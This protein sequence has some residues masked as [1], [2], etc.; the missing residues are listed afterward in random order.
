MEINYETHENLPPLKLCKDDLIKL[1]DILINELENELEEGEECI[2]RIDITLKDGKVTLKSIK[3]IEEITYDFP[4]KIDKLSIG[5]YIYSEKY[6]MRGNIS[7]SFNF[8]HIYYNIRG[9]SQTWVFGK[10]ELLKRTLTKYRSWY[11]PFKR[12]SSSIMLGSAFGILALNFT[13]NNIFADSMLGV[14]TP[15]IV[16]ILSILDSNQK[17]FPYVSISLED[18]KN[19][20]KYN[21]QL[22]A[23][24]SLIVA[25]ITLIWTMGSDVFDKLK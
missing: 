20:S 23:L 15:I 25:A 11:A 21:S 3:E 6:P 8:N 12:F 1:E 10:S 17:I 18:K 16:A 13:G 9:E 22:I 24:L 5:M 14:I 19:I 7:I 2:C 4:E